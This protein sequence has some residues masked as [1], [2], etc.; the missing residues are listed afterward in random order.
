VGIV[1][2]WIAGSPRVPGASSTSVAGEVH[3]LS[4]LIVRLTAALRT[5]D[6][7]RR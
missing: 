3:P 2:L 6:H 5:F 4:T 1:G 7:R